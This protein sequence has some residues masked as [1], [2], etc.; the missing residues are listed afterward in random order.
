MLFHAP[1]AALCVRLRERGPACAVKN[2]CKNA[3][4]AGG[5]LREKLYAQHGMLLMLLVMTMMMT[6]GDTE[7]QPIPPA[8]TN[9]TNARYFSRRKPSVYSPLAENTFCTYC[10]CRT[11]H[12]R[13]VPVQKAMLRF[14]RFLRCLDCYDIHVV[15]IFIRNITTAKSTITMS[16]KLHKEREVKLEYC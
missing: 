14:T 8:W 10:V 7:I 4:I 6:R 15:I 1:N 16:R 9:L 13:L 2:S 12:L 5:R 3:M 11:T